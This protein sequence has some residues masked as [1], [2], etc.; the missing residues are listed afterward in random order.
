MTLEAWVNPSIV[1]GAW[2]DVIYKGNDNYFMEGTSDNDYPAMGGTFSGDDVPLVGTK[3]LTVNT[4]AHLAA[5]LRWFY[6]TPVC[7]WSPGL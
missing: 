4:W 6:A 1:S 2:R 5:T 3:A 7:K